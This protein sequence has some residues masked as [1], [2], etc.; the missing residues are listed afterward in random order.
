MNTT[1]DAR[2]DG[3]PLESERTIRLRA[4][5]ILGRYNKSH[6]ELHSLLH[7]LRN[8][9]D[10][11]SVVYSGVKAIVL[12]V[13]KRLNTID[14]LISKS[15]SRGTTESLT[16]WEKGTLRA[17]VYEYTIQSTPL[18]RLRTL[19]PFMSK[20]AY[21]AARRATQ[22]DL[23]ALANR[24]P[25]VQR[26][27]VLYSHPTFMVETLLKN[28]TESEAIM[29]MEANNS[30]RDY[31]IRVN[32]LKAEEEAVVAELGSHNLRFMRDPEVQGVFRVSSGISDLVTSDHFRN[33][34]ILV[35]DKASV[36]A[37]KALQAKEGDTVWDACAAPGMKTQL[38][39][40]EMN[41]SGR[42]IAT[43]RSMDRLVD[44]AS[45]GKRLGMD[46]V[47]W[48]CADAS[49]CPVRNADLI[50]IDAPCSSTGVFRS[51]P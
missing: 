20:R 35:Q 22:R 5:Q 29:L 13:L 6:D 43:D 8:A 26:L 45:R 28:M 33:G 31:F 9:T 10:V 37:A 14:F 39:W 4:A 44:A 51:H 32:R 36:L 49:K 30:S 25:E 47:Q 16:A 40:E 23:T 24:L 11:D 3:R 48:V 41:G 2:S 12:G 38:L 27:S 18:S 46:D 19:Y 34:E 15:S 17:F 42:L 50:L 1:F 21:A 7:G